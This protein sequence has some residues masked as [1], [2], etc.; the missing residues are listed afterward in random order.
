MD[1]K[2]SAKFL[3]KGT[4]RRYFLIFL[5]SKFFNAEFSS[6]MKPDEE[7]FSSDFVKQMHQARVPGVKYGALDV[8]PLSPI[9]Y[10]ICRVKKTKVI[11]QTEVATGFSSAFTLKVLQDNSSST[12]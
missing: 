6:L 11:V 2:D 1:L 7:L 5:S 4:S 8:K 10:L 12:D 3:G 9:L